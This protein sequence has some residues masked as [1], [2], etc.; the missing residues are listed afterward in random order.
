MPGV[1]DANRG[2]LPCCENAPG[3]R[4]EPSA[5]LAPAP[6]PPPVAPSALLLRLTGTSEEWGEGGLEASASAEAEDF[7]GLPRRASLLELGAG[8]EEWLG[9]ACGCACEGEGAP[10]AG[11]PLPFCRLRAFPE[12]SS[13]SAGAE[14]SLSWAPLLSTMDSK[15]FPASGAT[16]PSPFLS[17]VAGG[18]PPGGQAAGSKP[19][20]LCVW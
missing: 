18:A 7:R 5:A 2:L 12:L 8:G 19:E 9:R 14:C 1:P 6:C 16:G 10:R 11:L 20:G 17:L 15:G 4:G 3:P 13:T